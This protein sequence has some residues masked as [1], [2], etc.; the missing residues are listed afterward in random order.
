MIKIIVIVSSDNLL[1]EIRGIVNPE[2]D[3]DIVAESTNKNE[4]PLLIS[5]KI[6]DVILIDASLPTL[7]ITK[8]LKISKEKNSA[9]RILLLS[10]SYDE[11]FIL[12]Q[13]T[14][15]VHGVLVNSSINTELTKAIKAVYVGEVWA[16]RKVVTEVLRRLLTARLSNSKILISPIT[17]R[18]LEIS[19]LILQGSSNKRIS[20]KLSISQNTVKNHLKN[21]FD[22][23]DVTSRLQL[24]MKLTQH[25]KDNQNIGH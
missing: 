3:L 8:T 23:F 6:P 16:K 24:A 11:E 4:I 15:G 22:K 1:Q 13:L 9:S 18:E 12:N 14:L 10:H 21:L 2:K 5:N 25:D 17:E 19:E 7:S 20:S